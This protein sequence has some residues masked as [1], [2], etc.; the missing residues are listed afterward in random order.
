VKAKSLTRKNRQLTLKSIDHEMTY[1][2]SAAC[3]KRTKEN[4]DLNRDDALCAKS[5]FGYDTQPPKG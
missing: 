1:L 5:V 3:E 4:H 2:L